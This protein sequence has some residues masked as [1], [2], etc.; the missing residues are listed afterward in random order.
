MRNDKFKY[1]NLQKI[2]LDKRVPNQIH[3]KTF[4]E[5]GQ[6]LAIWR[7]TFPC[8][9]ERDPADQDDGCYFNGCHFF[10]YFNNM[11]L[12]GVCLQ[13]RRSNRELCKSNRQSPRLLLRRP[14][15][16]NDIIFALA[17]LPLYFPISI[18]D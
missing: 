12:R 5:K 18:Q 7:N 15:D 11:S 16:R 4:P 9:D 6:A 8:N 3:P 17:F 2:T 14:A 1:Q 10:C 13:P